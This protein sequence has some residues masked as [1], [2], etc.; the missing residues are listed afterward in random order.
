MRR[1]APHKRAVPYR[2]ELQRLWNERPP[3]GTS[4]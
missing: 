1:D 2:L 3:Y 4:I